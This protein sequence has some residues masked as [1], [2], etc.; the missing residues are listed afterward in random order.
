MRSDDTFFSIGLVLVFTGL[1]G[2]ALLGN[3]RGQASSSGA[4][5]LISEPAYIA[6]LK[7]GNAKESSYLLDAATL[8]KLRHCYALWMPVEAGAPMILSG[9]PPQSLAEF[10][11]D[12]A[13]LDS[14]LTP[15]ANILLDCAR[16]KP[17]Q[18]KIT[19]HWRKLYPSGKIEMWP[20]DKS[21]LTIPDSDTIDFTV[22]REHIKLL[23]HL[24]TVRGGIDPKRP[25]GDMTYFYIDMADALGIT[26]KRDQDNKPLFSAEQEK[27]CEALHREMLFVLQALIEHGKL[28][29]GQYQLTGYQWRLKND[30]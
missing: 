25:Y 24:N 14:D 12:T 13:G 2:Y 22:T 17:G 26:V 16:L 1:A 6:Q 23:R 10:N 28:S 29:T 11:E 30:R 3:T 15:P 21:A 19:N 27:H 9:K 4:T 20:D 5:P 18:Y 8:T 7:N